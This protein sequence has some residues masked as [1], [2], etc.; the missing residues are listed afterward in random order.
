DLG[1]LLVSPQVNAKP[2]Q[3]V[4]LDGV[5]ALVLQG[6]GAN[7]IDDADAAPLLL[8]VNDHARPFVRNHA[9]CGMKLSPAVAL[10]RAEHVARQT[11]R[12]N[13][14]EC[15]AIRPRL[16]AHE[17]DE[18]LAR[19]ERA[20]ADD[21]ELAVFRRQARR[22]NPLDRLLRPAA[23]A[24]DDR[25]R[26]AGREARGLAHRQ[27]NPPSA[28]PASRPLPSSKGN[29]VFDHGADLTFDYHNKSRKF[30]TY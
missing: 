30:L 22:R 1:T 29:F 23:R 2:E 4:G 24:P 11:L 7:L 5:G 9:H 8:L 18:L 20:V 25:P 28:F 13:A 26:R 15:R 10:D 21:A 17:R 27:L 6:V 14:R 19:G 16:P 3:F 12:V